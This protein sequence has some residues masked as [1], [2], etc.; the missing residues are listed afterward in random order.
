MKHIQGSFWNPPL[1]NK[2]LLSYYSYEACLACLVHHL[3]EMGL[4]QNIFFLKERKTRRFINNVNF[5]LMFCQWSSSGLKKTIHCN[6]YQE[7]ECTCSNN[8]LNIWM[9]PELNLYRGEFFNGFFPLQL[10]E[11]PGCTKFEKPWF[12]KLEW[13]VRFAKTYATLNWFFLSVVNLNSNYCP[14]CSPISPKI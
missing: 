13:C 1:P 11:V 10:K 7:N 2:L 6:K 9:F 14:V 8:E 4:I 5:D 12:C 3:K